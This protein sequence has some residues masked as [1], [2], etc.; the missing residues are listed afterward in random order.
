MTSLSQKKMLVFLEVQTWTTQVVFC[1]FSFSFQETELG[2]KML[3]GT[4]RNRDAVRH[5]WC[6]LT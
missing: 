3:N 1:F 6:Q 2:N 5:G 4:R